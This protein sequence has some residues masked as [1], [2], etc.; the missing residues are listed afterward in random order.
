L[1]LGCGIN[2][3]AFGTS[4]SPL[5]PFNGF[6]T[7]TSSGLNGFNYLP[8]GTTILHVLLAGLP[9]QPPVPTSLRASVG[10][11]V[12][13]V[14]GTYFGDPI[15]TGLP[16][17]TALA[18]NSYGAFY[19][20]A[21]GACNFQLNCY[22][23]TYAQYPFPYTGIAG[24]SDYT[25][26]WTAEVDFV[27][28]YS[29]NT[30][31]PELASGGG[32]S[33]TLPGSTVYAQYYPPVNGLLMGESYHIIPGTT[34]TSGTSLTEDMALSS[35]FLDHS[36]AANHLGPYAQQ[37]VWQIAGVRNNSEASSE[38]E[39]DLN[40]FFAGNVLALTWDQ[41]YRTLSWGTISITGVSGETWSFYTSD[42]VYQAF[43]PAGSYKFTISEA[44]YAPQSWNVSVLPGQTGTGQD[45]TY[46]E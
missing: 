2:C 14:T 9:Q 12:D 20:Q 32:Q 25:G 18:P 36:M 43:L 26:G 24:T 13:T 46:L 19:N 23:A 44:G 30:L 37:G 1:P 42:G 5:Y 45:Y 21:Q 22:P 34:A 31:T 16:I 7:V 35:Q 4:D 33:P 8:S 39:V 27:P 6:L 38:F 41:E 29:S 3:N 40:G 11:P 28:W 17:A 15:A 10:F